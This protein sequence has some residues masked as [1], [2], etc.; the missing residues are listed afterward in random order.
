[1][2]YMST[3]ETIGN[4]TFHNLPALLHFN[5]RYNPHLKKIN[6]HAF[7]SGD[8]DSKGPDLQTV[9][10]NYSST[11]KMNLNKFSIHFFF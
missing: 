9:N 2:S 6:A 1:M 4:G 7:A 8:K 10:D 5:C 3:L 11:V